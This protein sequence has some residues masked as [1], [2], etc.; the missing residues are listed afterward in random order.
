MSIFVMKVLSQVKWLFC[1]RGF[2]SWNFRYENWTI[3]WQCKTSCVS[4]CGWFKTLRSFMSASIRVFLLFAPFVEAQYYVFK[5]SRYTSRRGSYRLA[6]LSNCAGFGLHW[7]HFYTTLI[8]AVTN[9]E[10]RKT[11]GYCF[12]NNILYCFQIQDGGGYFQPIRRWIKNSRW[13]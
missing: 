10:P 13:R 11:I 2:W 1:F 9:Q 12:E 7:L 6:Q 4:F 5:F 3:S 8:W